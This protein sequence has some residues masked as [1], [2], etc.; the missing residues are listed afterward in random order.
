MKIDKQFFKSMLEFDKIEHFVCGALVA[1]AVAGLF[2]K[3]DSASDT[4]IIQAFEGFMGA[5]LAGASKEAIDYMFRH[6]MFDLKDWLATIIGGFIGGL[7][8]II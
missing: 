5:C 8:W 6:G 3:W 7:I 4:A 1:I 2:W